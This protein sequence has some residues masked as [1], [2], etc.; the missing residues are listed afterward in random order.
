M[1]G[2]TTGPRDRDRLRRRLREEATHEL[3]AEGEERVVEPCSRC[4]VEHPRERLRRKPAVARVR[5]G[6]TNLTVRSPTGHYFTLN[7]VGTFPDQQ[8]YYSNAGCTGTMWL[9]AGTTNVS[10]RYAKFAVYE[11]KTGSFFVPA[12]VDANGMAT[13]AAFT[14]PALWNASSGV[15]QCVAG[16]S[17]GG[18]SLTSITR[19]AAGIATTITPPLSIR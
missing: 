9:N 15:W 2:P 11:A 18:W 1:P 10:L 16:G 4:R 17:N 5:V 8:I 6:N 12:I 3:F 19:A 7:W 14:A 13:N